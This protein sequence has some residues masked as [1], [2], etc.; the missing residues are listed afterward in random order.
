MDTR[1]CQPG[2]KFRKHDT[3]RT[4]KIF[5]EKLD[6]PEQQD[7]NLPNILENLQV[8]FDPDN[9]PNK[10]L[11]KRREETNSTILNDGELNKN[12]TLMNRL[13]SEGVITPDLAAQ[14]TREIKTQEA[15]NT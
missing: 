12:K 11:R 4:F 2:W 9:K 14:L 13:V 6:T 1:R 10:K 7:G 15:A 3:N 5:Q 8:A